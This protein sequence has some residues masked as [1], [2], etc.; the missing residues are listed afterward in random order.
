MQFFSN[1]P[2]YVLVKR[3]SKLAYCI[4]QRKSQN[5]SC[6]LKKQKQKRK[7]KEISLNFALNVDSYKK[8]C[9][10]PTALLQLYV[11]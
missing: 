9:V 8:V 7:R 2:L 10:S 5:L 3:D 1:F 6:V 4:H 11:E